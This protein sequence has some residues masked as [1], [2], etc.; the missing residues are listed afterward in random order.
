MKVLKARQTGRDSGAGLIRKGLVVT[1]FAIS[2]ILIICTVIIYQQIQHIKDRDLGYKRQNLLYMNLTEELAEHFNTIRAELLQTGAI[3]DA[4]LSK[5]PPLQMWSTTTT[6]QLSWEGSDPDNKIKI[7]WEGTSPEYLSTMGLQLKEG[8]NFYP[9]I[10]SDS[11]D[12]IINESMASLM[13]KAGRVGAILTYN[14]KYRCRIVGI[15]K[16]FLFNNM[17]GSV[18]P[19]MLS[20]DPINIESY[21]VLNIRLKAGNDLSSDLAKV[22]AVIKAN[23]PGYPFEYRF[24]D[25]Q[26]DQLFRLESRIGKLAGVFAVL[27]IFISCLGL[28]G[29]AAFTAERRTKEIGIRKVLGA[30]ASSLA[31]L[32][33]KEFLQLVTLSCLIA[34][35]LS[36][37][38]MNS[39][40]ADFAY[41]TAIHWWVFGMAGIAA[42]L[43]AL[44]TVSFQAVKAA[45]LNPVKTLRSE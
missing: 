33:S 11:G 3:E 6:N 8:R 13:G 5:S 18:A 17:Y 14:K 32:L 30:S 35:P 31:T 28:F 45:L 1:Q 12:V 15:V 42:L 38:I 36:W 34:F 24:V 20:C 37:W 4:A 27:A 44:L 16:D 43:I 29:L 19:L 26:F 25:E 39:W 9:D 40:L 10:K 7:N 2:V 41:H 21:Q 22:E 23:N